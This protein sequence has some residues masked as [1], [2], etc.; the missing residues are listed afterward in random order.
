MIICPCKDCKDR[1]V[2][3]HSKCLAYLDYKEELE[4]R[5]KTEREEQLAKRY[6]IEACLAN[7]K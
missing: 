3:C 6:T 4:A 5:K 2:G 1:Q 7:K